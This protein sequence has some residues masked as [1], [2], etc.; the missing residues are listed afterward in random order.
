MPSGVKTPSVDGKDVRMKVDQLAVVW[1]A[2]T[3]PGM[4]S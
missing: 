4:T 1:M 2:A 3:M